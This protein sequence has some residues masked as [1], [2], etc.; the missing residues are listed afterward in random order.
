MGADRDE[1][2]FYRVY[3]NDQLWPLLAP[4]APVRFRQAVLPRPPSTCDSPDSSC[5]MLRVCSFIVASVGAAIPQIKTLLRLE[6]RNLH[7]RISLT[8]PES[9]TR[10]RL[11]IDIRRRL[12]TFW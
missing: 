4:Q 2:P 10:P 11:L 7:N 5:R 1:E 6:A 9:R 3:R 8:F 12:G